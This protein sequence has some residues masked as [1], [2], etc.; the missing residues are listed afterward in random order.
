MKT[1]KWRNREKFSTQ[2]TEEM[3]LLLAPYIKINLRWIIDLSENPTVHKAFRR[4]DERITLLPESRK[5]FRAG[6]RKQ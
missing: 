2:E 6:R 3:Q 5:I 4:K 1:I